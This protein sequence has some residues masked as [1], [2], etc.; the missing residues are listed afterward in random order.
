MN[1]AR[2]GGPRRLRSIAPVAARPLPRAPGGGATPSR[3]SV[4]PRSAS[5]PDRAPGR[6]PRTQSSRTDSVLVGPSAQER[7]I[8]GTSRRSNDGAAR[9]ETLLG[10]DD[11]GPLGW[12]TVGAVRR[13]KGAGERGT[14]SALLEPGQSR[15]PGFPQARRAALPHRRA[16]PLLFPRI[17]GCSRGR[18]PPTTDRAR[19]GGATR[20]REPDPGP[21]TGFRMRPKPRAT[22]PASHARCRAPPGA[23]RPGPRTEGTAPGPSRGRGPIRPRR[24]AARGSAR[25]ARGRGHAGR[26]P[27]TATTLGELGTSRPFGTAREPRAPDRE[28]R[29]DADGKK[30]ARTVGGL[31]SDSLSAGSGRG[32][33]LYRS[34]W[35]LRT[36]IRCRTTSVPSAEVGT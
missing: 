3:P 25:A 19:M 7:R 8:A 28:T 29:S 15:S 26:S 22:G 11:P 16:G 33:A 10:R 9:S 21:E 30:G 6:R 18:S 12:E 1:G 4:P 20:H 34:D 31:R 17:P 2:K 5:R 24:H 13:S 36:E 35:Y 32:R 14:A 23:T 27:R